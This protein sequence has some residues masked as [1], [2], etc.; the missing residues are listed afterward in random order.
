MPNLNSF[1]RITGNGAAIPFDSVLDGYNGWTF[2]GSDGV[3]PAGQYA[4]NTIR[5]GGQTVIYLPNAELRDDRGIWKS[6]GEATNGLEIVNYQTMTGYVA[7]AVSGGITNGADA[8]LNSL[9]LAEVTKLWKAG[10]LT[11]DATEKTFFADTGFNKVRVNVGRELHTVF[12]NDTGSTLEEGRN[13]NQA[14]TTNGVLKG[15]YLDNLTPGSRE[16]FLGVVTV[17]GGVSNGQL[18][19][20]TYFGDV[21]GDWSAYSE[22]GITYA[23]TNGFQTQTKPLY[24]AKRWII[25]AIQDNSTNG[26]LHVQSVDLQRK[27]AFKSY[28]FTSS[29]I[30][31]GTYWKGGFYD[32]AAADAN[33]TQASL[34][35][36]Y[37]TAGR[38]YSAH[39]AIV[40]SGPGTVTGGGQ[41]GIRVVGTAVDDDGNLV[42]NSTN[43]ISDNIT[44]LVADVYV[45]TVKYIGQVT[46]ELYVVSGTP[47][48]YSLDFNYGF[49]KY[50]DIGNIDFT[51]TDFEIVGLCGQNDT[52]G[53]NVEL[54]HHKETG[55]TYA[56]T[57]FEPGNSFVCSMTNDLGAVSLTTGEHFAYKRANLNTFINGNDS[58]GLIVRIVTGSSGS[59]QSM[60]L[61]VIGVSEEL[62]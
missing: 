54:L 3:T 8:E 18:G 48:T 17:E 26:T 42:N 15:K 20:C 50:E 7:E 31:A 41:V 61:H 23:G 4:R 40:P 10:Q 29:G 28:S 44:N 12:Y 21:D 62:E 2:Y 55:W 11:Y 51:V 49:A 52:G 22:G 16:S 6:E 13:I 59:V 45:E 38:P 39:A 33:L 35:Q 25:G 36:T 19:L 32:F 30:G 1:I 27:A 58:E 9:T 5:H 56:A 53:F 60:D 24:P 46:F 14:G 57:G 34:T 43:V 47:T 37:G